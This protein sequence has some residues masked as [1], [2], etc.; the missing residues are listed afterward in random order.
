MGSF[1]SSSLS[2][3]NRGLKAYLEQRE[4]S[5]TLQINKRTESPP[6][7]LISFLTS[8]YWLMVAIGT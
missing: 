2:S 1:S 6:K 3:S 8:G 4:T 5:L 7:E